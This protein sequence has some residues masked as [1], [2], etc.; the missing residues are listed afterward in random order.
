[1]Q[2]TGMKEET[3]RIIAVN[4]KKKNLHSKG[5]FSDRRTQTKYTVENCS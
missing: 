4:I 1:M 5:I 3:S 2:L